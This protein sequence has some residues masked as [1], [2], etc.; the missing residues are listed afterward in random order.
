LRPAVIE[1][2]RE[3]RP[4]IYLKVIASIL[5]RELHFKSANAFGGMS[6]EERST[7][8][9]TPPPADVLDMN[10]AGT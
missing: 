7:L 6:D 4:E 5:P 9:D 10:A 2:V 1:K 8:H 3:A